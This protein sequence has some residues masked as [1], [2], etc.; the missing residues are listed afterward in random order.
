MSQEGTD[1]FLQNIKLKRIKSFGS[2][3]AI[4]RHICIKTQIELIALLYR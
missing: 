1:N 4:D 3:N 2:C